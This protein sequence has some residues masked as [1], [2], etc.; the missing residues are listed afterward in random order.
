MTHA[1]LTPRNIAELLEVFG[2]IDVV[3]DDCRITRSGVELWLRHGHISNGWHMRFL[4]RALQL[5][6]VFDRQS[7]ESIFGLL[8][9]QAA[10][11][12]GALEPCFLHQ[13]N[14]GGGGP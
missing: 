4:A 10:A 6:V 2:G 8:P 13:S 14:I 5:G 9:E 3:A 11:I 1:T 7:L 12:A